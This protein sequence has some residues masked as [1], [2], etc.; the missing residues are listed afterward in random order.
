MTLPDARPTMFIESRIGTP[1]PNKVPSVRVKRATAIFRITGPV[2]GIVRNSLCQN[3]L[4]P[5]VR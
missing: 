4:P 5:F 1:E 2:T 3:R